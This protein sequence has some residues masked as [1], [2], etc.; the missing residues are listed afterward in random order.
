[1]VN[2]K[3]FPTEYADSEYVMASY[4]LVKSYG[5]KHVARGCQLKC[6]IC[7]KFYTCKR[8]HN[9]AEDHVFPF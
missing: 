1:M 4:A 3:N 9:I 7:K 2:F 8:C 5:C 6:E